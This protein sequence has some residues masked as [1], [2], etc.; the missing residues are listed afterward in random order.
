MDSI[1]Y[2]QFF[3]HFLKLGNFHTPREKN[4]MHR[5]LCFGN[6]LEQKV[7]FSP[8]VYTA[9]KQHDLGIIRQCY[10]IS[11]LR[12]PPS[13]IKSFRLFGRIG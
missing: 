13:D 2:P 10:F 8:S 4:D 11:Y 5:V 9:H 3:C 7:N 12:I 6:A 1:A